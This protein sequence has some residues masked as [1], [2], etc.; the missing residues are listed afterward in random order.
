MRKLLLIVLAFISITAN[1]QSFMAKGLTQGTYCSDGKVY[2]PEN[3]E[4]PITN[5]VDFT[6]PKDIIQVTTFY[7]DGSV[8][9]SLLYIASTINNSDNEMEAYDFKCI[10]QDTN[11]PYMVRY[12][13]FR[14]TGHVVIALYTPD[15]PYMLS[16]IQQLNF[17]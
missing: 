16:N 12:F 10:E 6:L 17:K 5:I 13:H 2:F 1:A 15:K 4:M 7:S 3:C 9:A 14:S 11:V 8:N